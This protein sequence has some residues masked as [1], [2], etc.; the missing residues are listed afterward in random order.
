MAIDQTMDTVYPESTINAPEENP[1]NMIEG[2]PDPQQAQ[3]SLADQFEDAMAMMNAMHEANNI[4]DMLTETQLEEI[5]TRVYEDYLLDKKSREDWEDKNK[6]VFK[7]AKLTAERKQWAGQDIHSIKY[8]LIAGAALQFNSRSLPELI[9]DG[10]A[11]KSKV[12]G[13]DPDGLKAARGERVAMHM[14]IQLQEFVPGW[15]EGMDHLLIYMPIVGCGFKKTYQ[16]DVNDTVISEFV[17]AENLVADYWTPSVAR[18]RRLTEIM[19]LSKNEIIERMR[20]GKYTEF[21]LDDLGDVNPDDEDNIQQEDEDAPH[22]ILEQ[23]R[24]LDLDDDGYA[25]PYVVLI[26]RDTQKVLRISARFD[27][28]TVVFDEDGRIVRIPPVQYYT[29][30]LFIPDPEGSFYGMGFGSLLWP[31]NEAINAI[32]NQLL[33]AGMAAN[34]QGGFLGGDLQLGRVRGQHGNIQVGYGEWVPVKSRGVDIKQN[35]VPMP[36]PE[37]SMVLFQLL[38]FLV[39]AGKELAAQVDILS[40]Q[41]P[42]THVPAQSTLA[43]IEQG[44][45]VY[46]A[47]MKRVHRGLKAEYAKIRRLNWLY[48]PDEDYRIALDGGEMAGKSDYRMGDLDIVP[49]SDPNAATDISRMMKAQA[50]MGMLNMGLNDY[51]IKRRMLE[52]MGVEGVNEILPPESQKMSPAEELEMALKQAELQKMQAEVALIEAKIQTEGG[53]SQ[54]AAVKA[55]F[56]AEKIKMEK[57]RIMNETVAKAEEMR[58]RKAD[59]MMKGMQA[60][61]KAK[62]PTKIGTDVPKPKD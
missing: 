58:I 3:Q 41:S 43:L 37:P 55:G 11:V 10:K 59:V 60:A 54:N 26:H 36:A 6:R 46:G 21:D 32:I 49:V 15:E 48:L 20:S 1:D 9:K 51:V 28:E 39:D 13:F 53:K 17:M 57:A 40:G 44:L 52:A 45:K 19:Q 30:Y 8:P 38:G 24:Y 56:D 31:L 29:R 12:L 5:G 22:V 4:A 62:E 61:E 33:D 47:I 35:I 25:E 23:H 50:L 7:L 14:S 27:I 16:C 2:V 34:R 42:G 18:A